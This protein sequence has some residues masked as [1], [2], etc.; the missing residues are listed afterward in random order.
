MAV[1]LALNR[2]EP[3]VED[4]H[5][6]LRTDNTAAM[7]CI[8]RRGGLVSPTL[9]VLARELTLWCD[10]RLRSIRATHLAGLQNS[11]ADLL[12]RGRY[13]YDDWSLHPGVANQIFGRCGSPEVDLF[14]SEVNAKCARFFSIRGTAPLGLEA[15][16]HDWPGELLYAFPPLRLIHQVLVRV[17]RLSLSVLLVAPGWGS[18]RSEIAPL[19]YDHP[20][21]LPPLRDLLSQADGDIL[22]PRPVELDRWV[23]PVR[24]TA[25]LP[26]D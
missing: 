7:Y 6:L 15:L 14:A 4:C 11:G 1:L 22:H 18:W 25:W 2:F 20:W 21:R 5:V 3:F 10:S 24:G 17:R 23:W 16:A 9:D 12:S 26:P 8:N 13:Y 19:L